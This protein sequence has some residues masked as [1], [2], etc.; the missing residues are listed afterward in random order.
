M[1]AFRGPCWAGRHHAFTA[2]RPCERNETVIGTPKI[3]KISIA[4]GVL[5]AATAA[6]LSGAPAFGATTAICH[7]PAL[8]KVSDHKLSVGATVCCADTQ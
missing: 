6:V 2:A 3:G 8:V 7:S 4:A 5:A 1:S